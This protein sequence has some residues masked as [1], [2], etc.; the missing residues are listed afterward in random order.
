MNSLVVIRAL[1]GW[2]I[3]DH[4]FAARISLRD[5]APQRTSVAITSWKP[6]GNRTL[7]S[8]TFY[9]HP[10]PKQKPDAIAVGAGMLKREDGGFVT[11]SS[12]GDIRPAKD[13]GRMK[14]VVMGLVVCDLC[15]GDLLPPSPTKTKTRCDCIGFCW[16][17]MVDSDHRSQ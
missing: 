13:K 1:R 3:R 16:W 11:T 4:I 8:V 6:K 17:G 7:A 15:I 14:G 9:H 10:P 2:W 12:Q 5:V